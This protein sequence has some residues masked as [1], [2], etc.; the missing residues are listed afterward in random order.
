MG[1]KKYSSIFEELDRKITE[2][3]MDKQLFEFYTRKYDN[4]IYENYVLKGDINNLT[5]DKT[6][7]EK[8]K[9]QL[10]TEIYGYKDKISK[11]NNELK[12]IYQSKT[13]KVAKKLADI[14]HTFTK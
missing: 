10:E 11:L 8:S 13:W 7:L 6:E 2:N 5:R 9:K 3:I 14:K 1:I 4:P 12:D